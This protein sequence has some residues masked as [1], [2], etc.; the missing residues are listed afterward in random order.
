MKLPELLV[1]R[2]R[3]S[4]RE[5]V[6]S[7]VGLGAEFFGVVAAGEREPYMAARSAWPPVFASSA[8]GVGVW[9]KGRRRAGEH[10][11]IDDVRAA[12]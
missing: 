11:A 12:F 7:L 5:L 1:A 9:E 4:I 8:R 2:F 3:V 6:V 10:R